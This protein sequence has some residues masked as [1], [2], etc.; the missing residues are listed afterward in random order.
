MKTGHAPTYRIIDETFTDVTDSFGDKKLTEMF[1]SSEL[2]QMLKLLTD[3]YEAYEQGNES[4]DN[5]KFYM[6]QAKS[7]IKQVEE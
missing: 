6:L 1:L 7:L 2:L 5:I 3:R 4:L